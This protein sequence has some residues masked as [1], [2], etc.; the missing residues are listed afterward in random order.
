ME[1]NKNEK[2]F[3]F[4]FGCDHPLKNIMMRH[5]GSYEESRELMIK[6]FGTKWCGQYEDSDDT[7]NM[8]LEYNYQILDF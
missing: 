5:Y 7:Q 3:Y 6:Y 2:W 1:N 4:T 8:I